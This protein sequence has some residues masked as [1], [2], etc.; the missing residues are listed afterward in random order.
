M[1]WG[2][3]QPQN[4]SSDFPEI[5]SDKFMASLLGPTHASGISYP[6][7]PFESGSMYMPLAPPIYLSNSQGNKYSGKYVSQLII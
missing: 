4:S 2:A 1:W 5:D 7:P 6:P 3:E